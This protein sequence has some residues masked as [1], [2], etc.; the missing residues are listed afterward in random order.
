MSLLIIVPSRGRP[1]NIKR[2]AQA[3][4]DTGAHRADLLIG[5]DDD[6][7]TIGEYPG[8]CD[9]GPR[10]RMVGTLNKLAVKY[11]PLYTHIGFM[12]DDHCPRT[13]EWNLTVERELDILGTGIVYGNDLIQG[14][15]IP[16]AVFMTSDIIKKLG[17]MALPGLRHLFV[18]NQWKSLGEALDA[19]TY[20]PD[21]IIEHLH[22]VAGKTAWDDSYKANNDSTTWDHDE[23][24][25]KAWLTDG[26]AR[27]VAKIRG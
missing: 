24:V 2:L 11:A 18:D 20:L 5:L 26:L 19:L 15:T 8:W 27:D 22:P 7:P 21:V 14:A 12:G 17:W 4:N 6:D 16:T 23:K 1:E 13:P 25:Y 10:L 9:I 3:W